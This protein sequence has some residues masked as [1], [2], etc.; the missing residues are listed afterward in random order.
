MILTRKK[1]RIASAILSLILAIVLWPLVPNIMQGISD[2]IWRFKKFL[3]FSMTPLDCFLFG[4]IPF[5]STLIYAKEEPI[6]IKFILFGI[7]I[8]AVSVLVLLLVGFWIITKFHFV[9]GSPLLPDYLMSQ[10][11]QFYWALF[12]AV[13]IIIPALVQKALTRKL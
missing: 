3:V 13:G 8:L 11:F 5:F 12:T 6:K 9:Y 4:F 2:L 1:V 10:P 7:V